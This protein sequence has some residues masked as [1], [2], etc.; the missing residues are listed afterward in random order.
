MVLFMD[1]S[2]GEVR[3]GDY[4]LQRP[5]AADLYIRSFVKARLW[6]VPRAEMDLYNRAWVKRRLDEEDTLG[7]VR[8]LTA[9]VEIPF[10][11]GWL[12]AP[13]NR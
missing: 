2:D 11:A 10:D 13:N 3:N 8:A 7:S 5:R 6:W 9:A 4:V 12:N 1:I